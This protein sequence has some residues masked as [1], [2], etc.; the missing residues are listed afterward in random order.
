MEAHEPRRQSYLR[1]HRNLEEVFG[2]SQTWSGERFQGSPDLCRLRG[3][4]L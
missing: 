2:F 4:G 1:V 3:P